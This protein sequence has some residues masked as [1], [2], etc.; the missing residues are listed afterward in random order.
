M[1]ATGIGEGVNAM[2]STKGELPTGSR[3]GASV[4]PALYGGGGEG[5]EASL[6]CQHV[7][8]NRQLIKSN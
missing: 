2:L 3:V 8:Q 4:D 7:L 6:G 1:S 5:M